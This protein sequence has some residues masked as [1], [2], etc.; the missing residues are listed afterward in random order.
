M[1]YEKLLAEKMTP[2]H[3]YKIVETCTF[4]HGEDIKNHLKNCK[5]IIIFAA[6]LG[7]Q[8][9]DLIRS[10]EV[11]DMAGAV[12]LDSLA[13]DAI[14]D[15]CDEIV[16]AGFSRPTEKRVGRPHP[17]TTRFSPG[18][19]DFPL[20]VQQDLLTVL[21]A[22]KQIGL[23]VTDSGILIPRKSITAIIGVKS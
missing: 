21:N 18:Y 9:D 14:E 23:Y 20:S 22:Q 11:S 7:L 1:N 12:I 19:G 6:T 3:V 8:V 17:Y 10:L 16:G 4:L 2:R 5:E 15:Y 13:S